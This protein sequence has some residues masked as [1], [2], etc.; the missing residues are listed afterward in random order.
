MPN[1]ALQLHATF[2]VFGVVHAIFSQADTHTHTHFSHPSFA[3]G[4]KM[5]RV[6]QIPVMR[7]VQFELLLTSK[8][9]QAQLDLNSRHF[10][11]S[12]RCLSNPSTALRGF[13]LGR[14]NPGDLHFRS[15]PRAALAVESPTSRECKSEKLCK[16][17][18]K[19]Y[20]ENQQGTRLACLLAADSGPFPC[21]MTNVVSTSKMPKNFNDLT[22]QN[23]FPQVQGSGKFMCHS[24][25]F[26]VPAGPNR[27]TNK[28]EKHFQPLFYKFNVQ[29]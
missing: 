17:H 22:T 10:R 9:L 4:W 15:A 27:K 7:H 11:S 18:C 6:E 3:T 20:K 13:N 16:K 26:V 5:G 21:L 19:G 14:T 12:Y 1:L 28:Q 2:L 29:S 23:A 24:Y 25:G 8:K